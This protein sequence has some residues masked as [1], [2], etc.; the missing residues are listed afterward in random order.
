[1]VVGSR[2]VV[3]FR[4]VVVFHSIGSARVLLWLIHAL[5]LLDENSDRKVFLGTMGVG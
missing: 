4:L 2:E 5:L 3:V 1:M